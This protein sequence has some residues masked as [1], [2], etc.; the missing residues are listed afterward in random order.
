MSFSSQDDIKVAYTIQ[1]E[2]KDHT[3]KK[4]LELEC[5]EKYFNDHN[6]WG[7]D[8]FISFK[9]TI[10]MIFAQFDLLLTFN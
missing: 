9:V 3:K 10:F 5:N 8:E 7:C 1:L 6:A 2:N 4:H